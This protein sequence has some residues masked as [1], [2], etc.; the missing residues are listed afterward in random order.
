MNEMDL[1]SRLRDE[2]PV[3]VS[4]RAEHLFRTALLESENPAQAVP[5]ARPVRRPG[6]R[7]AW[8]PAL[9]VSL[10]AAA[11]AAVLVTV[12][13]SHGQTPSS[14]PTRGQTRSSQPARGHAPSGQ[15][16][17]PVQLLADRAAAAAL[18]GPN[19]KPGQW[20]YRET[21]F[22]GESGGKSEKSGAQELWST[23]D[24]NTEA[25]YYNGKLSVYYRGRNYNGVQGVVDFF[26]EPLSY[27]SLGSLPAQPGALVKRLAEIGARAKTGEPVGCAQ[28]GASCTAF[29]VISELLSSYVMPPPL[30][31]EM[32]QALGDIPGVSVVSHVVVADQPCTGFRMPLKGG[33]VELII[34]SSTYQYMATQGS[35]PG[36]VQ[37]GVVVASQALVS[38]PG[39]RP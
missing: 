15:P 22:S 7:A 17:S 4:P 23:A 27:H 30:T 1:L 12:L 6:V 11:A 18:S 39:V 34:N 26:P 21:E 3:G 5:P 28:S 38:G 10:A 24:D 37:G 13:P 36:G 19:V 8:R 25:S 14:Q 2:V 33:Y 20:V 29:L 9:A 16:T 31:A 32:Y 35:F